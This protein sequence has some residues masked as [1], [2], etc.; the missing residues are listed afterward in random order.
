MAGRG[1]TGVRRA[2]PTLA[3]VAAAALGAC[4][5]AAPAE[6]GPPGTA[7]PTPVTSGDPPP[8]SGVQTPPAPDVVEAPSFPLPCAGL[9]ADDL[10]ATFEVEVS[11][12]DWAALH[13]D[14]L[15]GEEPYYPAVF[16]HGDEVVPDAMIRLRGNNS[17]CGDKLQFA[18]SFNEVNPSG[19]FHGL[20]RI[21]LD[22][23]GCKLL[24]ERL[25][26]S[27]MRDLGLPA[28]CANHA[29]LVVNGRYYGLFLSIEHVNKD[30]LRRNF[31]PAANDGNLYKSGYRLRTNEEENDTSDL[32]AYQAA[33]DAA[34]LAALADLEEAVTEWAA[35][36]VLPAR[37]NY[38]LRGWNY[39]LYHHP[40]RGFLFIPT[41]LDRAFPGSSG[42]DL[43]TLEP[44]VLQ[45]AARIALADPGWRLRYQEAVRRA[46]AAYAP[47]VLAERLDRWWAQV[48][49]AAAED[50]FPMDSAADVTE[51]QARIE[52][53]AAWLSA[54]LD[55]LG[56]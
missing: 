50:P 48:A 14:L 10:L 45:P 26:L 51:L 55:R 23:G 47:A 49:P 29:R 12:A 33:E 5:G 53:R 6:D 25:A 44:D 21:D 7:E 20:R 24:E 15:E 22:H 32:L 39:Y 18:I 42:V 40:D 4:H 19:R 27:F 9:H 11:E 16:R 30:F 31:G 46:A 28:A 56:W 2:G 54:E 17:R 37:D 8:S 38:W 34:A 36:A 1:S 41:D 3:V 52:G 13:E 43:A 35:E